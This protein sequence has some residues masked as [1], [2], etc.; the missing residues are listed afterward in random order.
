MSDVQLFY[1]NPNTVLVGKTVVETISADPFSAFVEWNKPLGEEVKLAIFIAERQDGTK[2]N[3]EPI[4][5]ALRSELTVFIVTDDEEVV[6]PSDLIGVKDGKAYFFHAGE[7]QASAG[8]I[9]FEDLARAIGLVL[10][11]GILTLDDLRK[12]GENDKVAARSTAEGQHSPRRFVDVDG[13]QDC[14]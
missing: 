1:S 2:I 4:L 13:S 8:F 6:S 14:R 3:L 9:P 11:Y 7:R 12:E 5:A 10:R